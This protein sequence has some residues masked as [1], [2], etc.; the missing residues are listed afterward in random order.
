MLTRLKQAI[1]RCLSKACWQR[2]YVHSLRNLWD[3]LPKRHADDTHQELRS[4]YDGRKPDEVEA[5][6]A[7]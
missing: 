3:R 6:S 7:T 5:D 4:V 1:S 2:C